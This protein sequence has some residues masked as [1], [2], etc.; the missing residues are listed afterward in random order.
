ML[1][2]KSNIIKDKNQLLELK[3]R[4]IRELK[5]IVE[6]LNCRLAEQSPTGVKNVKTKNIDLSAHE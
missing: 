4:E 2:E 1:E 6:D 3:D 5:Y